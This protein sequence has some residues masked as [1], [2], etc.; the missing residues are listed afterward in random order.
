MKNLMRTYVLTVIHGQGK[1]K[2]RICAG[3]LATAIA[4][5]MTAEKCPRSA[6]VKAKYKGLKISTRI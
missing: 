2:F 3:S 1:T 5:L 6:I 4:K